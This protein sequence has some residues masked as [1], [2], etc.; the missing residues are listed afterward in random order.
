MAVNVTGVPAHIVVADALTLTDGTTLL[1]TV[2]TMGL[3]LTWYVFEQ[4][5]DDTIV[6]RM[7]APLVSAFVLYVVLLVPTTLL[8]SIHSKTGLFPPLTGKAVNVTVVPVQ[9]V[10]A[11]AAMVTDGVT[12][13][14]TVMVMALDVTVAALPQAIEDTIVTVTISPFANELVV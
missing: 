7:V 8:L 9:I 13:L 3:A 4:V 11:D 10:V 14:V 5:A 6:S 12:V 2:I 1:L